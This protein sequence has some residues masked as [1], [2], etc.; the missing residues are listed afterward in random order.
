[1]AAGDDCES[2]RSKLTDDFSS[3]GK[4]KVTLQPTVAIGGDCP[5]VEGGGY[6]GF[7]H[8]TYRIEIAETTAGAPSF[9]FSRFNGGLVGRGVFDAGGLRVNITANLAAINTSGLAQ[10]Y[11]EAE[12]FDAQRG[13]WRVTYGAPV[14]LNATNQLVLPA[15]P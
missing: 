2:I 5:V 4:L 10:F 8:Q 12:E 6:T 9:K 1:M 14:T 3:K 11:L 15:A 13:H 7:E